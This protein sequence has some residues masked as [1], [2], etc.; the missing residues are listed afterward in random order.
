MAE[1]IVRGVVAN[2][3]MFEMLIFYAPIIMFEKSG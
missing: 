1:S 3:D 2:V